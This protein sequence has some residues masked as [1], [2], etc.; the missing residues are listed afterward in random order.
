MEM[1]S[2]LSPLCHAKQPASLA[3]PRQRKKKKKEEEDKLLFQLKD[4]VA[5]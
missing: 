3:K 4:S 2:E 1:C 5:W